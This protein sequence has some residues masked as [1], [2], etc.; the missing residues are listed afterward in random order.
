M[1]HPSVTL[2]NHYIL[3]IIDIVQN[4]GIRTELWLRHLGI[5]PDKEEESLV[6]MPWATFRQFLLQAGKF[7]N[8][9]ALGLLIG[10]RLLINTHG[11]LGYAAMSSGT[12]RQV[13]EL[14]EQ[15]LVLRTDL[16]SMETVTEGDRLW[17]RFL[18][19]RPLEDIQRPVTEAIV[20]AIR[21]ILDFTTMGTCD[22][23]QV[24]FPF[25]GDAKLAEAMFRSPVS[26]NQDVAAF[27]LPLKT[28]DKPLKMANSVSFQ[29][30]LKVCRQELDKLPT[31]QSWSARVRRLLLQTQHGFPTLDITARRFYLTPRTLHR[32]L[33]EEG[34][35][36][37][38]V[39]EGVRHQLAVRYLETGRMT[40]QEISFAL[41]Y[42]DIANFRKA[43]KRWE[44]IPPS[45]YQRRGEK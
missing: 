18:E 44:S 25:E 28:I 1:S 26:Y 45:Q 30:A 31:E 34:T 15:Y 17:V 35:S 19:T 37:R 10:E 3:Q 27:S 40:I 22:I 13:I 9:Q 39:L 2:P 42:S 23:R 16:L 20:L 43:F 41:G 33:I 4:A 11:I 6:T 8:D 24:T 36:Y 5:S 7:C 14:L 38:E 12:I 32:R 29:E 21:N